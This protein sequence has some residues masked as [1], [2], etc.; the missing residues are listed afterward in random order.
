MTTTTA[1]DSR[2]E[3][4]DETT[5]VLPRPT[6]L[7]PQAPAPQYSAPA[8]Y[9]PGPQ[10]GTG[11]PPPPY[12]P[13]P[14]LAQPAPARGPRITRNSWIG[15]AAAIALV[16]V[17]IVAVVA[18]TSAVSGSSQAKGSTSPSTSA[19]EK[20]AADKALGAADL[21]GLLLSPREAAQVMNKPGGAAAAKVGKVYTDLLPD[22]TIL[23]G[24]PCQALNLNGVD[25]AY[26]GTGYTAA[27]TLNM[28]VKADQIEAGW[29]LS[30][31]V[32]AYPN[33]TTAGDALGTLLTQ[34][35]GCEK[36]LT[37]VEKGSTG[38]TNVTWSPATVDVSDGLASVL[39]AQEGGE[40]W[41]C[42]RGLTSVANVVVDFTACAADQTGSVPTATAAAITG[43]VQTL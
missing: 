23:G 36:P 3:F 24:S 21:K 20:P 12:G 25:S 42:W 5:V 33:A 7:P 39:I 31:T 8:G 19:V 29:M 14:G 40:G 27:R 2:P 41:G 10:W 37:T 34:W 43:K 28:G 6:Q 30:Q 13:A 1:T 17:M 9:R 38:P 18:G 26:R 4:S 32:V 35:H 16:V 11:F 22:A 15:I